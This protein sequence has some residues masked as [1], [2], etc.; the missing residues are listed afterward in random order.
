M[1]W[2]E[3]IHAAT[4]PKMPS[5]LTPSM[6]TQTTAWTTTGLL[7]LAMANL[8]FARDLYVDNRAGDDRFDGGAATSVEPGLGPFRTLSRA[9]CAARAG[10][11]ILLANTGRAYRENIS[12]V[13]SRHSGTAYS[14]FVIEGQG[15][16]LD[17]S[18]LVPPNA[19]QFAASDVFRFQP[20]R[21]AYQQLFLNGYPVPRVEPAAGDTRLPRLEPQQWAL[22]DGWIYFCVEPGKLPQDYLLTYAK[23]SV[24]ITL[25]KVDDVLI[26]N[27]TVQGFQLDGINFHDATGPC[28][29]ID[30]TAWNNGRSG[31]AVVGAS[32]AELHSCWL[33]ANGLSQLLIVDYSTCDLIHTAVVG[34]AATKWIVGKNAR[35]NV[36]GVPIMGS[37]ATPLG[38]VDGL[39]LPTR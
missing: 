25:Y 13:G 28:R 29:L 12:L 5:R 4:K 26:H 3:L 15:A 37:G 9:V 31:V 33:G 34:G 8:T 20:E 11:R 1:H 19:W 2:T 14:P 24:G 22:V 39:K 7:W 38:S 27:L 23:L 36:D 30:V 21:K 10:D 6:R 17:G 18:A 16:V 32:T 35:L